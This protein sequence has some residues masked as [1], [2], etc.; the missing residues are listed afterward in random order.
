MIA[1]RFARVLGCMIAIGMVPAL[2]AGAKEVRERV[3]LPA[4]V[5]PK[6][7]RIDVTPDAAAL[8]FQATVTI[9]ITVH[10]ATERIVLNS[11]DIVIDSAAVS[12][13]AAAPAISYDEKNETAAFDL[14][15]KLK[16]GAYTLS[17]AY[18]GKIF[19]QASGF[20]A[21]DYET[22]AGKARALFTQFENSDARRFVPSWDEP[23]RKATFDLTATVP[24][25]QMPVSNMPIAATETLAGGLKR[26]RFATSPKMSSYLL[27]FCTGDFERVHRDVGGVDVG[28]VVKR[29]DTGSAGYA[30]DAAAQ[31]LPYYNDYF[32]VPYPLPKLDMIAAP[33]GSQFFGAME[34]WGAIMYFERVL[35][36]DPRISTESD[37]QRV[38]FVVA[39]EMAH[40]WFGDLVTMAWWD[41]LWLNEGFASWMENKVTDHYHPEWKVWLQALQ[42]RQGIKDVDS[43][44]GTHPQQ[45]AMDVDARIGTH[46]IITPIYDVTQAS[47]AFDSAITYTKGAAVIQTLEGYLGEAEFRAG[48]RRY[49]RDHAYG[50]TVTDDLWK[51]IDKGSPRPITRIAHDLTLQ[52]GVPM[53]SEV[54]ARCRAGNTTLELKQ[55][56][57]AIDAD[58]T[59]AR[60][61]QVPVI[62]AVNGGVPARTVVAGA[63]PTSLKVAGCGP[64]ILNAGQTEYFRSQ[65]TNEGMAAIKSHFAALSPYDQL[66]IFNDAGSLAYVGKQPMTGFLDLTR[67]I[68]ADADP[69]VISALVDRL[70][71]LDRIYRG[72]PAQA[73]FR[74]Y[75]RS[76]LQPVFAR[77]G[78]DKTPGESDN[79]AAV[80][81]DLIAALCDFGDAPLLAEARR[82][83][84]LYVA[85]MGSL[86]AGT[87]STVLRVL[88]AHADQATWDRLHGMAIAAR[89]QIER[90]ELYALLAAAEDTRLV[91][92]A[93]DLAVTDEPPAT[94]APQMISV[95]S[96]R[97]PEMAFDF[98]VAH[99]D[100]IGALIEPTTQGRYMPLLLSTAT[101]LN[102]IAKLDAFADGHI[103][104]DARQDVLKAESLVR[105][106]AMVRTK[107]LPEVDRWVQAQ[108]S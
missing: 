72:L 36:I 35:L 2:P 71:G 46:P 25:E 31:I 85:D 73:A 51:E 47:A 78:W 27:Y 49:M 34:N 64:V 107:R 86:D 68:P 54:S 48:V 76:A 5:T 83:F 57:F 23:G 45:S 32:G 12:G 29:G 17:L 43:R 63:R 15:H 10:R 50:N 91:Q 92:Q 40:Q 88:A 4:N 59:R 67:S 94:T 65:Y 3:M 22:P 26:V 70:H 93:L 33:G 19:R 90:Q 20:F 16:P 9:D 101:D 30:L 41:D 8:T 80:R 99:W 11:A 89:T 69:L 102:V 52:A 79:L 98:A 55:D 61:W 81:G 82:R 42:E 60:V 84:D 95:A 13:E 87:R 6:H 38:Y 53:V 1:N 14:G 7:Y 44:T 100:R 74:A 21:L 58:S 37:R 75:A 108:R 56:R 62:A 18:H 39:H 28:V 103:E 77:I 96:G 105:Y 104:A 24:A 66:G 106:L 97:H